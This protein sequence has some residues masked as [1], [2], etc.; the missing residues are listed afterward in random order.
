MVAGPSGVGKTTLVAALRQRRPDLRLS[1]SAT[2]RP[3]RPGERDGIDYLFLSDPEFDRWAREGR[4]LESAS[5]HGHRYG[6][7]RTAVDEAIDR[8]E[9]VLLEID[10]QGARQVRRAMPG[11][12]LI[13]V[14]PPSVEELLQRLRSRGTESDEAVQLRL[15]NARDEIGAAD[16]FDHR[17]VNDDLSS[18]VE[19]LSRILNGP[20]PS[21]EQ[22]NA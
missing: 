10:V 14:E 7:P 20:A 3:R 17:V 19:A 6:T 1:V 21:T 2:T 4:F 13:F 12:L 5:V 8:G 16:E 22:E 15:R 11:A 18:A 9:T